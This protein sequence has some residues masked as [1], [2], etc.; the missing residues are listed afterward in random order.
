MGGA[1]DSVTSVLLAYGGRAGPSTGKTESWDGTS[2]TEVGRSSKFRCIFILTD[3]GSPAGSG[4]SALK[5]AGA[6][7][8][9]SS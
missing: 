3:G 9:N 6:N 1:G 7:N 5:T 4:Q 8:G 2:W